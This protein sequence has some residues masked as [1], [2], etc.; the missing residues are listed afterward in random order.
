MNSFF[1]Y[2]SAKI[3]LFSRKYSL[4]PRWAAFQ[5]A[6]W[7][8][9]Q[10]LARRDSTSRIEDW[11]TLFTY[12]GKRVLPCNADKRL[13]P[14]KRGHIYFNIEKALQR[15]PNTKRL[16]L[17]FFMGIG[18][19]FYATQFIKILHDTYPQL[20]LDAY[21]SDQFDGNNS[22]LVATCLQNNPCIEQIYMYHG[23]QHHRYWKDYDWQACYQKA[24]QDTLLLPM[25]YEHANFI[26]SRTRTLCETF[27]LVPPTLNPRPLVYN[28]SLG[29]RVNDFF[30]QY[31]P[32]LNK[33]VFL[34][35]SNRS[36]HFLYPHHEKLVQKLLDAGYFV[37]TVE[38]TDLQSPRLWKVDKKKMEITQSIALLQ[39]LRRRKIPTYMITTFSCFNSVSSALNI[40]NLSMQTT[41]DPAIGSVI[42]GNIFL[43][44]TY[45]YPQVHSER[46]FV[47]PQGTYTTKDGKDVFQPDFVKQCFDQML[48]RLKE[49]NL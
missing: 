23:K 48:Q 33:V 26:T 21:V 29:P 40:P 11:Y 20:H 14:I 42:F 27:G 36:S 44:S 47:A 31:G 18:D 15:F 34:Q 46:L 30:K 37:V 17:V 41:F 6:W 22:P 43:I 13:P 45:I 3:C 4:R 2:A 7:S 9:R 10:V 8:F 5:L 32:E 24:S 1:D 28:Y 25:V 19:Y 35:C 39:E 49:D 38:D 12:Y 16:G